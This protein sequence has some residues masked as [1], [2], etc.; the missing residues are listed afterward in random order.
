[1]LDVAA[2]NPEVEVVVRRVKRGKAAV[3]RGH[4]SE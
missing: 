3:I 4:Y 1:V 2:K